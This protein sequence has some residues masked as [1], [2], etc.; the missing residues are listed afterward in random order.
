MATEVEIVDGPED[1]TELEE[2]SPESGEQ[3]VPFVYDQDSPNLVRDFQE[4]PIGIEALKRIADT[5]K[6]NF[7]DAYKASEKYR[8]RFMNDWKLFSGELPPKEYPFEHCANVHLPTM[9]EN[10][11]RL[12]ARLTGELFGDWYNVFGVSALGPGADE[13]AEILN[14]HGNWQIRE[15]IPDFR[16]QLGDRGPLAYLWIGDV[17]V[18]SYYDTERKQNRHEVLTPDEFVVPF[19]YTSTMPDYSD[20]PW[21]CKILTKYR[22]Q[23]EA[24]RGDWENVD[25]VLGTGVPS[26]EETPEQPIARTVAE[27][28]GTEQPD[29]SGNDVAQTAPYKILMYEGWIRLP[30]D[31]RDRFVQVHLHD[32]TSTMLKMT[33]HEEEDWQDAERFRRQQ[34][35]L[36]QYREAQI[37]HSMVLSQLEQQ[38]QTIDMAVQAGM[39]GPDLA[40]AGMQQIEQQIPPQ[41][42]PPYWLETPDDPMAG[43]EPARRVPIHMFT[44]IVCI[45]S[46]VGAYGLGYGRMLGDYNRA[47]NV[48]MSQFVDAGTFG[49]IKSFLAADGLDFGDA[50]PI[51]PGDVRKV[52]GLIG[53]DI[54]KSIIP[55]D[56]GQANGQLL[57]VVEMLKVDARTAMQAPEVLSGEPGKSGETYRGIA[58]RIEQATKQLSVYARKYANG[59]E[60][61]LKNNAKLNAKW[62]PDEQIVN[63]S[64]HAGGPKYQTRITRALYDRDYRV[65]IRADLRFATQAQR[66]QEADEMLMLP[67]K[68]P[69]MQMNIP[70]I[71]AA[72]VKS[73]KARGLEEMIPLLGPPPPPPTTPLGMPPPPPPGAPPPGGPQGG[74]PPA[75]PPQ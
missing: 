63:I 36:Q 51:A 42:E 14:K 58:A 71:Y 16:R 70:F 53:D 4:H 62:L 13:Q 50:K 25:V 46:F 59:L 7:D 44:H 9:L 30:N 17:C 21:V 40:A 6:T 49:N 39:A 73:L 72:L 2:E 64:T 20:C 55:V 22:H 24:L 48:L 43:P 45:E 38:Q 18:H 1:L 41:P 37:Q 34:R 29:S 60:Q 26:Y 5:V 15:E 8:E 19:T 61:V 52:K 11:T 74:A 33:V 66:I 32:A 27:V 75:G 65:E 3:E 69:Q 35:E 12:T 68:V 28:Q 31:E 56:A 10:L 57:Q 67:Q 54:R 23:L 47:G